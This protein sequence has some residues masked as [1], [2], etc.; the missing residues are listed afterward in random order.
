MY[1]LAQKWAALDPPFLGSDN[2]YHHLPTYGDG[3]VIPHRHLQLCADLIR[4]TRVLV[5]WRVGDVLI[6]DNLYVRLPSLSCC[7][8]HRYH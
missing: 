2:A 4:E 6:L 1:L 8:L 7:T 3:S 5:D